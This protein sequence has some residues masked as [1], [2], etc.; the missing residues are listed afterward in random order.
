MTTRKVSVTHPAPADVSDID[1]TIIF[2]ESRISVSQAHI[3]VHSMS[4]RRRLPSCDFVITSKVA[5]SSVRELVKACHSQEYEVT[6]TNVYDILRLCDEME[7]ETVRTNVINFLKDHRDSV[8]LAIGGLKYS[9]DTNADGS[10]YEQMIGSRLLEVGSEER[11][12]SSLLECRIEQVIR[13]I[14]IWMRTDC[15]KSLPEMIFVLLKEIVEKFGVCGSVVLEKLDIGRL[16]P[17]Q[18]KD[19]KSMKFVKWNF[20]NDSIFRVLFEFMDLSDS[21]SRTIKEQQCLLDQ[22]AA[23]LCEM[24]SLCRRYDD[25]MRGIRESIE[26]LRKLIGDRID[27][28]N[29]GSVRNEIERQQAEVSEL[30][31]TIESDCLRREEFERWKRDCCYVTIPWRDQS[32]DGIFSHLTRIHGG[33]VADKNI[34]S[35]T[36]SSCIED[37]QHKYVL[38]F[39]GANKDRDS[40][41]N[42]SPG[43]W[44]LFDLQDMRVIPTHYTI[45]SYFNHVGGHHLKS[46]KVEGS[47][48]GVK[49]TTL[50]EQ[51][52][53][54]DL[55]SPFRIHAFAM[56]QLCRCKM[57]RLTSTG[58]DH[59]GYDHLVISG[60]E[61]FGT[62]Q[63]S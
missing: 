23:N 32:M 49:W 9:T 54:S 57:I 7:I 38:D 62:L 28:L 15:E 24:R 56:K 11:L 55:N 53:N 21:Q 17:S 60:F 41:S 37:R 45:R 30:K 48:D 42:N 5:D 47:S 39:E 20:V 35:V 36:G 6:E 33:N 10:N 27:C 29:I 22:S 2:N 1:T 8:N 59:Y 3:A 51:T 34:V 16:S 14:E 43:Q 44:L 50:D 61:L 46:W 19:L 58:K 52:N 25:D 4:F 12:R 13:V 18:M 31:C 63:N 40:C 26:D